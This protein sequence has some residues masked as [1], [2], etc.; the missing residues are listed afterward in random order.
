MIDE[1]QHVL[2]LLEPG[3]RPPYYEV[4]EHVYGVGSNVDTEGNS[5]DP[6]TTQWTE[7]Y[8]QLRPSREEML[9]GDWHTH[10]LVHIWIEETEPVMCVG[11]DD[12][13]LALKT[14]RYLAERTGAILQ[15]NVY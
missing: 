1:Y 4:V 2:R 3:P 13:S 15:T 6:H 9:R 10:P 5:Y 11:S 12:E 7:L 14:A 8:M